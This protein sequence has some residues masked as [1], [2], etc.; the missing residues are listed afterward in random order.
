MQAEKDRLRA[1]DARPIKKVAEAKARKQKRM[2]VSVLAPTNPSSVDDGLP[3]NKL[4][5]L[6]FCSEVS[7][8]RC[9]TAARSFGSTK[10]LPILLPFPHCLHAMLSF[11]HLILCISLLVHSRRMAVLSQVLAHSFLLLPSPLFV[12]SIAASA[13]SASD[14]KVSGPLC[15]CARHYHGTQQSQLL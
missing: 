13:A 4:P 5:L 10:P 2:A 12:I 7:L 3:I 14:S 6:T 15:W 11:N 9:P 1:I 8:M